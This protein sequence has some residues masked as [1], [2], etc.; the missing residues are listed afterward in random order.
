MSHLQGWPHK[1]KVVG[2]ASSVAGVGGAVTIASTHGSTTV[3]LITLGIM[4]VPGF[5]ELVARLL[6]RG[7]YA[8]VNQELVEKAAA[9]PGN[10]DFRTLMIDHAST[11]PE[12]AGQRLPVR[13]DLIDGPPSNEQRSKR[14]PPAGS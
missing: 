11:S 3:A 5:C 13:P 14:R 4:Q 9:E 1:S 2:A 7:K 8:R 6:I 10:R 12:E